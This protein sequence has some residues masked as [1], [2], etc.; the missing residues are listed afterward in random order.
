VGAPLTQTW[1]GTRWSVDPTPLPRRA[2]AS[3]LDGVSCQGPDACIAVGAATVDNLGVPLA[4]GWDGRAWHLQ[5][6]PVPSGG[7]GTTLFGVAC[8][9][10]RA[11]TAVG[12]SY[13]A[14]G[15]ART[16]A[17]VWDGAAWSIPTT[18]DPSGAT[19]SALYGVA[20]PAP[21]SCVGAG[22][23]INRS[24]TVVTLIETERP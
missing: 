16:F 21:G 20:C 3:D 22:A 15:E 23:S 7:R 2:T 14:G 4:E 1:D 9:S 13:D 10:L 5:S 18:S 8:A 24:N 6:T 17:E 19:Y 12:T 11:C